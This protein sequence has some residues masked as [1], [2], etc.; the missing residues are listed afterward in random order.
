MARRH[1]AD[2]NLPGNHRD[3]SSYGALHRELQRGVAAPPVQPRAQQ[4]RPPITWEAVVGFTWRY[5]RRNFDRFT[6]YIHPE[7]GMEGFSPF[8]LDLWRLTCSPDELV[9]AAAPRGHAKS[10]AV[11]LAYGLAN[12]LLRCEEYVVIVSDTFEGQAVEHL[13]DYAR[14]LRENDDL[15]RDFHVKKLIKNVEG[16]IIV[17]FDDGALAR[18][19]ALGMEGA[20]R[21]LR[22][23][24]KRPGLF[25]IDDAENPEL[26]ESKLRRDKSRNWIMR[27]L[28]P[29][30]RKGCKVRMVGT[31]LHFDASLARFCKAPSW[32]SHV[33]RAH[34][35]FNDFSNILW[36]EMWPE[37]RLRKE[38]QRYIDQN[39]SHGYAQE[40]LNEPLSPTDAYFRVEDLLP[41]EHLDDPGVY[42]IGWDFAVSKLERSDYTVASIWKVDDRGGKKVLEVARGRWDAREIV[43]KL[44]DL[45]RDF[46]PQAHFVEKGVIDHALA[47]WIDAEGLK[48]EL[49]PNLVK[50]TRSIDKDTFARPLQGMIRKAAVSFNKNM[51]LWLDVEE[52]LRRFLKGG[53]DDIVDSLAIVAQGLR[54]IVNAPSPE[55]RDE[56]EWFLRFQHPTSPF[57]NG[58]NRTTGY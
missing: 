4:E 42:Y 49:Y 31:I 5:L 58:A 40:Y 51:A 29:A 37:E 45:E 38:R 1:G 12:V 28:I 27:D 55:E 47:P 44:L 17:M 36:P 7:T 41:A 50:L 25:I 56:E 15:I 6:P 53:H 30:G 21:G 14:E 46:R 3:F 16:D 57:N 10:T 18:V 54:D 43:D 33:W 13:R 20:I 9:A 32:K 35:S 39:D 34:D 2:A 26:V 8:H 23:R 11:T 22:W 24:S 52:E 19:R 48:R